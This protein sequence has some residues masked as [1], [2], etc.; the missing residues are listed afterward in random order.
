MKIS[1]IKDKGL[2]LLAELRRDGRNALYTPFSDTLVDAF[3]WE[4]TPE[5]FDFWNAVDD[6]YILNLSKPKQ[7]IN[8]SLKDWEEYAPLG[9]YMSG[10]IISM[11]GK[12]CDNIHAGGEVKAALEFVLTELGYE[13]NIDEI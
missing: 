4:D 6:G 3:D 1:E 2:R 12:K 13:V 9:C 5:E 8:I 7:K 11:D 10:T